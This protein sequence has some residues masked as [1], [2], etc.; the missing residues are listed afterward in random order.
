MKQLIFTTFQKEQHKEVT[1]TILI[2]ELYFRYNRHRD[3]RVSS[4]ELKKLVNDYVMYPRI[5][6][7]AEICHPTQWLKAE[8][9]DNNGFLSKE[10]F[11]QS[12]G[13][14]QQYIISFL[15][16]FVREDER[17]GGGRGNRVSENVKG[18]ALRA[19][20]FPGPPSPLNTCHAVL[21]YQSQPIQ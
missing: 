19:S 18:F 13:K 3:Q 10:E 14:L 17:K 2:D 16:A 9:K 21:I 6:E 4:F 1:S 8:D 15:Q 5:K 7:L 11:S 20:R 12:F